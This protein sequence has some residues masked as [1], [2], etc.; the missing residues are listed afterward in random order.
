MIV[1]RAERLAGIQEYFFSRKLREVARLR[2]EGKAVVNLGIGSP[3]LPPSK[4]TIAAL[5]AA[6]Y[7]EA[8]HGYQPY[9]GTAPLRSEMAAW[10]QRV[11]GV[12]LD[13]DAQVLPLLGSKEG[14]MY[15]SMA[16]LDAGDQVLL[17]DP[18]YPAYAVATHLAGAEPL[19]YDLDEAHGWLPDLQ[20]LEATDTARVKLMWVNYP[21]MPTG[22]LASVHD[23]A[24]VVGF[25]RSRR[26]LICHD[27]PYSLVLNPEPPLSIFGVQ[28]AF[29]N[30]IELNSLSKSY[31]MAGWR[32]GMVVGESDYLQ[33]IL[34]F[35]SNMDS[36]MFFPVQAA[37]VVALRNSEEWHTQQNEIYRRRRKLSCEL[38]ALLG[39]TF[40]AVRPGL[41]V[42]GRAPEHMQ[43]IESFLDELLVKAGV[44]LTPG[45]IFGKNG[46]R[47]IRASICVT[48]EFIQ[49]A[50]DQIIAFLEVKR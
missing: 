24:R 2:A 29:E 42:W 46:E 3:D 16:F 21:H 6:A 44:F 45:S 49:Q 17:P 33:T 8:N 20:K 7:D 12:E 26:I 37:A 1:P 36:G 10:Y 19:P 32:V 30:C 40:E 5:S 39:C 18:G 47:Y 13:P 25:A 38:M 4:E 43:N 48:E 22:A 50:I 41:F 28:G 27:N 35:K 15:I 23:L 34:T 11:Y 31:N 14:I 9:H